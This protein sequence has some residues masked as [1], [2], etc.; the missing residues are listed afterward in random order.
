MKIY[1][2]GHSV[3][4]RIIHTDGS[5]EPFKKPGGL[6]HS[7]NGLLP[8]VSQDDSVHPI[9]LTDRSN[10][11]LFEGVYSRCR[12][13]HI[14]QT[15]RLPTVTLT[16]S[17]AGERKEEYT[18]LQER[19]DISRIDFSGA[20]GVFINMITGYDL[21]PENIEMIRNTFT[22]D[23]YM[24]IH[25]LARGTDENLAR[26]HRPVPDIHQWLKHISIL[27]ANEEEAKTIYTGSENEIARFVLSIGVEFF[28]VTKG[29]AGVRMHFL[30]KN[31]PASLFY[32][33]KKVIAKTTVGC[34][35]VFGA[36]YYI[37][38][39]RTQDALTSLRT[40][41]KT[42]ADF[43]AGKYPPDGSGFQD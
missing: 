26:P 5:E 8:F 32:P 43:V 19:I 42:A 30:H 15:E 39:L 18:N 6:W 35:D 37:T 9:T 41:V 36:V 4:D 25:S 11:S 38:Y 40:A 12:G 23:I 13:E 22:G 27:Q 3:V 10:A 21:L 16:L 31:E 20:D 33:A 7:V 14:M 17:A 2:I 29:S 34:G 24:D 1:L 28:L